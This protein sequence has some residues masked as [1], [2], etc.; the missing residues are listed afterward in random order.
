M[1]RR[2]PSSSSRC[3]ARL[4]PRL[5][6]QELVIFWSPAHTTQPDLHRRDHRRH[7]ATS[8]CCLL[9]HGERLSSSR[10]PYFS[11]PRCHASVLQQSKHLLGAWSR[12]ETARKCGW[13]RC[14]E[15]YSQ[16]FPFHFQP[17]AGGLAVAASSPSGTA[18]AT[19]HRAPSQG[20]SC[21]PTSS[22]SSPDIKPPSQRRR[23][24]LVTDAR[25]GA[26]SAA[27]RPIPALERPGASIL[28]P[29][30]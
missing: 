15:L 7:A 24:S 9:G 16:P 20:M 14:L 1:D 22:F 2:A 18:L 12:Y 17:G 26:S 8:L 19:G 21:P 29:L 5:P 11:S 13:F 28:P 27:V 30:S 10:S 3:E 25:T 23:V 6:P 4:R